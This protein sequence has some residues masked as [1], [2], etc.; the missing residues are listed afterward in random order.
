MNTARAAMPV[1]TSEMPR[2]KPTLLLYCQHS[3]GIGHLTRS[4]ALAAALADRFRVVFLNGGRLPAGVAVPAAIE[5][6]H[7]PPLGMDDGHTLVSRDASQDVDA[8]RL[9][10]RTMIQLAMQVLQPAVLLVE[11]F[12]F[13]RKKFTARSCR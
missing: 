12:P 10:R 6:V 3:L 9:E 2:S 1:G 13:G 5:I 7:L 8:A 4:F 11:L